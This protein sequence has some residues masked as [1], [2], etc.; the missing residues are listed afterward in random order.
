M[1]TWKAVADEQQ[2][3]AIDFLS[4]DVTWFNGQGMVWLQVM[5]DNGST[6]ISKAFAEAC[7]VF[8]VKH[9]RSRPCTPPTN[10]KAVRLIQTLCRE[11]ASLM[12]FQNSEGP[13]RWLPCQLSIDNR[14]R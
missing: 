11:W 10:V 12:L 14:L 5:S 3:T 4:R 2:G 7:R 6:C 13:N 1:R 9:I 8:G